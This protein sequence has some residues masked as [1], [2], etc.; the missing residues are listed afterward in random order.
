V[1]GRYP[2]GRVFGGTILAIRALES[3]GPQPDR[4]KCKDCRLGMRDALRCAIKL[5]RFT[6]TRKNVSEAEQIN[7]P[8][9][10]FSY[11]VIA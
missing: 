9:K 1:T 3:V 6:Q 5:L 8:R 11:M 4:L 2:I 7:R 10:S